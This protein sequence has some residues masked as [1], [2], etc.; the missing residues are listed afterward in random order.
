M[1]IASKTIY[2]RIT[3][4]IQST[5]SEM[6]S[7]QEVVSTSKRINRLSDDPVGLVTVLDLRSSLSNI[8]QLA[9]NVSMGKSWLTASE[10]ALTQVNDI[11]TDVKALTVQMSSANT[12]ATER[13]NAAEIVKQYLD[14]VISLSNSQSGGRYLFSGTNT[15][16]PAFELNEATGEVDYNGNTTS[17]SIKIGSGTNIAVGK[18]GSEVFGVN[19]DDSNIFKTLVDLKGYL[20][21]NDTAG[22]QDIMGRLDA[23]MT[24]INAEISDI[25]G[26]TVR[27][28]VK[29]NIIADLKLTY[30][31]RKSQLED[32][33]VAE[34]IIEL[35]SKQL[36]YNAAL[37]SASKVMELSLVDFMA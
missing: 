22:I 1:R 9:R 17:F 6:F 23:H 7:A 8:E 28:E 21:N 32:A 25:G 14:E 19:W 2:D 27:M 15:D 5:Y 29:E 4:S 20:E 34:A 26:K 31:D 10:S 11:L 3:G 35:N 12:G 24:K 30:T 18:V 36:A 13:A 33:D 37:T 16:S